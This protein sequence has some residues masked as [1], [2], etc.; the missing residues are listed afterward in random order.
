M[1]GGAVS[2]AGGFDALAL[3]ELSG[4]RALAVT[5]YWVL[6]GSGLSA[7]LS[8][9]AR[10]LLRWLRALEAGYNPNP[11]HNSAH[12]AHVTQVGDTGELA[13]TQQ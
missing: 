8:L 2:L 1:A 7:R 11:Y 9:P 6:A 3:A 5:G 12:A 10:P 4:G 13:G